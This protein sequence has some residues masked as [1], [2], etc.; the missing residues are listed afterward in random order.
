MKSTD[1]IVR[2][3]RNASKDDAISNGNTVTVNLVFPNGNTRTVAF[4][5][6]EGESAVRFLES[7][8]KK[9]YYMSIPGS[10]IS[11]IFDNDTND[12]IPSNVEDSKYAEI[13]TDFKMVPTFVK[14]GQFPY[15]DPVILSGAGVP[16][17]DGLPN[18]L[19]IVNK[20]QF[21]AKYQ[22]EF[23]SQQNDIDLFKK[24]KYVYVAPETES[25]PETESNPE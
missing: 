18:L 16:L 25:T 13:E 9:Y 8:S 5:D 1:T 20:A 17:N 3:V 10:G 19:K 22:T 15:V 7:N 4:K 6:N 24:G 23:D 12:P 2:S 14:L 21:K 11:G